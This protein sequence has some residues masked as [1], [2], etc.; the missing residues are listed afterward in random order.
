[1][2]GFNEMPSLC[3]LLAMD[4]GGGAAFQDGT[5]SSQDYAEASSSGIR[6]Y[7]VLEGEQR[8]GRIR[9]AGGRMPASG[10]GTSSST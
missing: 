6:D 2:V 9:F 7:S 4:A 1:L 3:A 5:R 10:S 8:I